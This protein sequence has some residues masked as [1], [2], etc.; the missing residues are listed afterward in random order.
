MI[1]DA[2]MQHPNAAWIGNPRFDRCGAEDQQDG[3][4]SASP[5]STSA[6]T[7][8]RHSPTDDARRQ[9]KVA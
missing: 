6:S 8:V 5:A 2:W 3:R 4:T 1:I 7:P 9:F